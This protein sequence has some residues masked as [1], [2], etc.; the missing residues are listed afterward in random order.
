MTNHYETLGVPRDATPAQIKAARRRKAS[1]QHP[2]REGGDTEGMAE[3]NRAY[4]VLANPDSRARYDATGEDPPPEQ[5][6]AMAMLLS[7]FDQALR[8]DFDGNP[9]GEVRAGLQ[10]H[11]LRVSAELVRLAAERSRL[12]KRRGRVKT[13]G[14]GRNLYH[15]L[16]DGKV[17]GIEAVRVQGQRELETI[18]K[19]LGLLDAYE[20]EDPPP[21]QQPEMRA[22]MDAVHASFRYFPGPGGRGL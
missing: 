13:K 20:G 17:A 10:R 15:M 4:A 21:Q 7:A 12:L 5:D 1:E 19:A 18:G 22:F 2:D 8:P 16:I 6:E 9:V 14:E 11:E 3:V